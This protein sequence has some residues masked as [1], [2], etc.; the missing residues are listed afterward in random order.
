MGIGDRIKEWLEGL[1]EEYKDKLRGWMTSWVMGGLKAFSED[2]EPEIIN[3]TRDTL[4]QI[5]QMPDIPPELSAM[6]DK[7]LTEGDIFSVIM[8]WF[9]SL[10]GSIF[11]IMSLG[12]PIGRTWEYK[13]ERAI[14]SFR[15][16]SATVIRAWLRDKSKY[17]WLWDDLRDQGFSEGRIAVT[18]EL[19][20]IIPPLADM[21]RFADFSALDPEV[22][23][24]W[25]EFYD[26][27]GWITEPMSLLGIT[28]EAPRDWANKYWFSHW[29]QPGRYEL[30]DM[31]RRSLMGDPLIGSGDYGGEEKEGEAEQT[32]KLAYK[33]MGYSAF[34]QDRLLQLVRE[35]PT[36]VDVRRWWDMRT[37][38]LEELRSI[39]QRQGYFGK[40]LDN[41]VL[42]T[43]VYVAF[44]DLLARWKNGWITLDD[45]RSE[46]TQLGM[47]PERLEELIQTKVKTVVPKDVDEG[48]DLTKAEIYK[49]IKQ[50]KLTEAQGVDLIMEL[51]KNRETA[52]FLISINTAV[53]AGSPENMEEFRDITQKYRKAV[54][55]PA[56]PVSEALKKAADEVV[57]VTKE[58]EELRQLQKSERDKLADDEI[59]PK[60]ATARFDEVT[61]ALHRAE[62]ELFRVTTDYSALLAEW[63]QQE[64][65]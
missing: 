33:T 31:Y 46:L 55:V 30:G 28:N 23:E 34:W 53:L 32:I 24:A 64:A 42:W 5:K 56:K 7:A 54:G 13:Q 26:A 21:V 17:E 51:G 65:K 8:G 10:L 1:S 37:I 6:I 60:E 22:I 62:G 2:R 14:H 59:L 57:R 12:A 9:M 50:E 25:R 52:E 61:L 45:I 39:Y 20:K 38:D 15:L 47:P 49:G 19:A 29:I 35:I 16:D 43:K 44:P 3:L 58:V 41:Y 48:L 63:R 27:P 18:E 11:A 40:D 36:R 4:S